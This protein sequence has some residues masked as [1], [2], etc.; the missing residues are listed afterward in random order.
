MRRRGLA[1]LDALRT[2]ECPPHDHRHIVRRDL[3]RIASDNRN[4]QV[5]DNRN[6]QVRALR[7]KAKLKK[8]KLKD[9]V[10]QTIWKIQGIAA[11]M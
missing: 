1:E 9:I 6:Q 5:S 7:A 3:P 10:C 8:L 2:A 11:L 4:Q